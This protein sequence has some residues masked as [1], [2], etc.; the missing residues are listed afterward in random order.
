[1][2]KSRKHVRGIN[3]TLAAIILIVIVLLV[4]LL[5]W[6]LIQNYYAPAPE[7]SF[8]VESV[9]LVRSTSGQQSFSV[10]IKNIGRYAITRVNVTVHNETMR[11]YDLSAHP[12]E[13]GRTS[14]FSPYLYQVYILGNKYSVRIDANYIDGGEST[15][16]ATVT[17]SGGGGPIES[18]DIKFSVEGLNSS[19]IGTILTVDG[20]D[21][22]YTSSLSF[23]WLRGS[24][25]TFEWKEAIPAV[26]TTKKFLW[27][28]S[29]GLSTERRAVVQ[30]G[31]SGTITAVYAL[32]EAQM[33]TFR[34]DAVSGATG[35]ILT[36]D[37]V[38]YTSLPKTFYWAEDSQH[39]FEW[40]S[41]I[42][43]ATGKRFVWQSAS[44]LATTQSGILTIVTGG[45]VNATY[46][47]GYY[48]T[49]KISPSSGGTI[50]L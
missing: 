7:H 50:D 16:L 24:T 26:N 19:A 18:L 38:S 21:Y 25:H 37:G 22:N 43:A 36:V 29:S 47:T 2:G 23:S 39:S 20:V 31:L 44:G 10:T 42:S 28:Y 6:L 33:I 30:A 13:S 48:L 32:E 1:M 41:P 15:G 49:T 35:A 9:W 8:S 5:V 17:V 34:A 11:T 3:T 14:M 4:A 46:Q 45:S 12:L 27:K 40:Q